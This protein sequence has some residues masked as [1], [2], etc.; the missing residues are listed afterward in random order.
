MSGNC[1]HLIIATPLHFTYRVGH[2]ME[3]SQ[4]NKVN[5]TSGP[6]K[7]ANSRNAGNSEYELPLNNRVMSTST[8]ESEELPYPYNN[9]TS[10]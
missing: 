10:Y 3:H 9:I 2:Y 5:E 7:A 8:E 1:P 6:V 4:L